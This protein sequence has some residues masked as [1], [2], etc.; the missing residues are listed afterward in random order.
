MFM[1]VSHFI[2]ALVGKKGDIYTS[3]LSQMLQSTYLALDSTL[4]GTLDVPS[5]VLTHLSYKTNT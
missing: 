3:D 2:V 1:D 4:D 5:E